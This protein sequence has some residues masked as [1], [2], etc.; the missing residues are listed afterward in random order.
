MEIANLIQISVEMMKLL[1]NYGVKMSDYRYV[2]LFNEY[3]ELLSKGYKVS[4]VVALMA[5]KYHISEA[6]VYRIVKKMK[7]KV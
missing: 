2:C 4:Y 1:S 7:A 5:D 3:Q 6:S